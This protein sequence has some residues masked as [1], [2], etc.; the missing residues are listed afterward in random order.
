MPDSAVLHV[1]ALLGG[2]VD[3][4]LRDVARSPGRAHV[5]WH[6][7][8]T[9]DVV[10]LPATHRFFPIDRARTG[11]GTS[12]IAEALRDLRVG[13]VH[14]HA[15]ARPARAVA[16]RI[17]DALQVPTLVT[18]HDVLFLRHEAFDTEGEIRPDPA[19]LAEVTPVLRSAAAVLAPSDYIADLARRHVEGLAVEVV[20][21]GS[22]P[23]SVPSRTPQARADFLREAPR[24]VVA[25][26]GAIGP[27]KGSD[28]LEELPAHLDGTGIAIVVIGYLDRQLYPGWRVPGRLFVHGAFADEEIPGLLAAYGAK[29]A[30][31]PNRS[32]ESFSYT[33]SDVWAA[34]LPAL[35]TAQ[36]ALAERIGRSGGGWVLPPGAAAR[37]V[38]RELLRL[39]EGEGF[40]ELARVK[41]DLSRS[42]PA[43]VPALEDMARSLDAFYA[44]FA[45]DPANP[46]AASPAALER[47][48]AVNLDGSLFRQELVRLADEYSQLAE[49]LEQERAQARKNEADAREWI[50][51]I[52]RD[53]QALQAELEREVAERRRLGQEIVQLQIHKDAFDLLPGLLRRY[54]L[55]K[56]LDAR[57]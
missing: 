31:F 4:H 38:A 33:L 45:V 9:A 7:G 32:P 40:G 21:N 19:W 35:A 20:P 27:H 48:A 3:R 29:I 5:F 2:G 56:I 54:L 30:L 39:L 10:E 14:L 25:V 41:S 44:R 53:V 49:A 12:T 51:K 47:L 26:L 23:P 57:A 13:L 28:L 8:A 43:R 50:A 55:K 17:A 37:E 22:P 18:L 46:G 6:A 42:D 34:G 36:G 15:T 52:E 24:S 16:A 1:T 11:A